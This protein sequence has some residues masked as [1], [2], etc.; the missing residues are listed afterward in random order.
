MD[1]FIQYF[2]SLKLFTILLS[3]FFFA[4]QTSLHSHTDIQWCLFGRGEYLDMWRC[5][6]SEYNLFIVMSFKVQ[7]T[8]P[9]ELGSDIWLCWAWFRNLRCYMFQISGEDLWVWKKFTFRSAKSWEFIPL[10]VNHTSHYFTF[11]CYVIRKH[12]N[13]LF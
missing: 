2:L 6:I 1:I 3:G 11:F 8:D 9:E 12:K 5:W 7:F 10:A 4:T 13:P